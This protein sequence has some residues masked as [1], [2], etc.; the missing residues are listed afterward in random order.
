MYITLN[1]TEFNFHS[2]KNGI[3][4]LSR[5]DLHRMSLGPFRNSVPGSAAVAGCERWAGPTLS[6]SLRSCGVLPWGVVVASRQGADAC[7]FL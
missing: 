2:V 4:L 7:P 6:G 1:E 3:R 5:S